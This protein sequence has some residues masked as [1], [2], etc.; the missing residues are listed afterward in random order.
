MRHTARKTDPDTSHAAASNT[1]S[2][3]K[4]RIIVPNF[5]ESCGGYG[6]NIWE[7]FKGTGIQ[8]NSCSTRCTELHDLNLIVDSGLRRV[9]NTGTNAIVWV[10]T[11]IFNEIKQEDPD[12]YP[13]PRKKDYTKIYAYIMNVNHTPLTTKP[14]RISFPI[15]PD[16][17][18]GRVL[19]MRPEEALVLARSILFLEQSQFGSVTLTHP[20][21]YDWAY[22][23]VK[24]TFKDRYL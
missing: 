13:P 2:H 23:I 5:I 11:K 19:I 1:E 10:A 3:N 4:D 20:D 14:R 12:F 6:A 16:Y 9:T 15:P 7:I 18:G 24:A 8:V 17:F 22:D 21:L